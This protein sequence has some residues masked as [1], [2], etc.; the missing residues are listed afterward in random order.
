MFNIYNSEIEITSK[1]ASLVSLRR[2]L[3]GDGRDEESPESPPVREDWDVR[4]DDP[5]RKEVG[6]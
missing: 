3:I 4:M 5:G 1:I 2:L 6:V